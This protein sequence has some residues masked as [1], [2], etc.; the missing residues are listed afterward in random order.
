MIMAIL[1]VITMHIHIQI[2]A[3]AKMFC[4]MEA[5]IYHFKFQ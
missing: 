3:A 2:H 1:W 4:S 5:E